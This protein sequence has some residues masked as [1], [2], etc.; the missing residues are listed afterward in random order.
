MVERR[1]SQTER[2]ALVIIWAIKK[3]HL[4]LF[5]SHFKLLTDCKPIELIFNNSKSKPPAHIE[6]WNLRLQGYNFEV[7]HTRGSKSPSDY[8]SRH[9]S[10]TSGERQAT[11]AEEYVDFLISHAVPKA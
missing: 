3:L 4:Y 1:Y 10:P 5:G 6:H 7:R 8:L 2:E 11:M 9:T